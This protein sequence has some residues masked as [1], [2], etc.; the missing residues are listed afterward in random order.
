MN[1]NI[2]NAIS[3]SR[4]VLCVILLFLP[5][6]D[7]LFMV[8]YIVT[9]ATDILDGNLA[10]LTHTTSELGKKLDSIGDLL[11]FV[12][13]VLKILPWIFE[14][15]EVWQCWATIGCM[16]V[17]LSARLISAIRCKRL[18]GA[19]TPIHSIPNKIVAFLVFFLPFMFLAIKAWAVL[20]VAL[21]TTYAMIDEVIKVKR[22]TDEHR[23][24]MPC[25]TES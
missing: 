23:I 8:L 9:F 17:V 1:K 7:P 10:R 21:F 15:M 22:Y 13:M 18:T 2:P 6:M 24:D 12:V 5:T 3:V 19:F 14:Q 4:M 11:F 20:I 25:A 16:V